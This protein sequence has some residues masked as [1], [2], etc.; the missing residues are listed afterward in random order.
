MRKV[1]FLLFVLIVAQAAGQDEY[2]KIKVGV[3]GGV[4]FYG[5]NELNSINENMID[6]LPFVIKLIDDF[7][8][9]IY[10]GGFAQYQLFNRFY[11]GP[12]Y[13]YHYSGSRIG[14]KDYSGEYSFDQYVHTHQI[15]LK[16]NYAFRQLTK[17]NLKLEMNV[18]A[19]LTDWRME[20]NLILGDDNF[21]NEQSNTEMKGLSWF[22][23]PAVSVEYEL[24]PR[25]DIWGSL[26]YSFD[27]LKN[28]TVKG[29][30]ELEVEKTPDWS[31][32][33]LTLGIA[34]SFL[35]EVKQTE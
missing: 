34:V 33:K 21:I 22:V 6:Q 17:T 10:F 1:I 9:V 3:L 32:L 8:P 5:Q 23:T 29:N 27:L 16:A 25:V 4:A 14:A 12:N 24:L 15:G 31:G 19:N 26:G 7:K 18:G 13:E 11:L 2:K 28:Y 30:N 35:K 20:S